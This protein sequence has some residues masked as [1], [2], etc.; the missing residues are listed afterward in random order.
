MTFEVEVSNK[1][2]ERCLNFRIDGLNN[3]HEWD[4]KRRSNDIKSSVI[5]CALGHCFH[6]WFKQKCPDYQ[7]GNGRIYLWDLRILSNPNKKRILVYQY[8][9]SAVPCRDDLLSGKIIE[10]TK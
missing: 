1:L 9:K 10:E 7:E 2:C 8:Q 4:G 5:W 6:G 3:P